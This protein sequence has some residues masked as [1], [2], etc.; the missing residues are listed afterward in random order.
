MINS[1]FIHEKGR[2]LATRLKQEAGDDK[3]AQVRLAYQIAVQRQAADDEIK[4]AV[5]FLTLMQ[6]EH[7]LTADEALQRFCVAVF[8]FNEFIFID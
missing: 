4:R 8:S 2:A 1:D 6:S 7:K 5:D 3:A